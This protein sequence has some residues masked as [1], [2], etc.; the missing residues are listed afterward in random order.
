MKYLTILFITILFTSCSGIVDGLND[1]PNNP[2]SANY[3]NI[4]TGAEVGNIILQ[5]GETARRAGIF[6]GYYTG[7]DRQHLGFSQYSVTTSDF[8][9]LWDDAYVNTLRNAIVTRESATESGVNGVITG[10]TQVIEAL[11]VG[12][13]TSLYGDIPFSEAGDIDIENPVFE[14]QLSVY[15]ELQILLDDAIMNLQSGTGRPPTGSEIYFDGDPAP[16]IEVANTLKARYYMH[17]REYDNAIAAATNGISGLSNSLNAPHGTGADDSNLTYQFFAVAARNADLVASDYIVSFILSDPA[18]SPD[19]NNYRGHSKTNEDGRYSYYFDLN[20]TGFQPNTVDG[21]AIQD[22]PAPIVTYE[23]N[24]LILAEANFRVNGFTSGLN[25][26]NDFRDFMSTGG[27]MTGVDLS[28]VR[29]DQYAAADFANGGIEN[30]DGI[31]DNDA[32]LREILEERYITFFNQIEG[33][34]DTRRTLGETI[35]RVPVEPNTG[36]Q[37][38]QRFIYPQSEIDRNNNTPDPIP[39]F[40]EPTPVNQ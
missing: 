13:A 39:D 17:T 38:P 14:D 25:S 18:I 5:T 35:V 19:I 32:L 11:A 29:Y 1:D 27:Y 16:W 37:L 4:L 3:Q 36:S 9:D 8:D 2:T 20:S 33:F 24:L 26:L 10:I 22:A 21:M 6:A 34:N 40:F 28:N 7:I 12:T 23:E 31:S 30:P 15:A